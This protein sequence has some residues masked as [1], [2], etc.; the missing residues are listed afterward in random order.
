M[1]GGE[2]TYNY[3]T[4]QATGS[5][6]GFYDDVVY[7][8]MAK[9]TNRFFVTFE[10]GKYAIPNNQR[11]SIGTME[12]DHPHVT[13]NSGN[14]VT[15]I[16]MSFLNPNA[17]RTA[18]PYDLF[19]QDEEKQQITNGGGTISVG[20]IDHQNNGY[21]TITELKGDRSFRSTL[22]ASVFTTPTY[23]YETATVLD[24]GSVSSV[25]S[26]RLVSASYFYPFTQYQLA[27]LRDTPG[28]ILN[29]DKTSELPNGT[30]DDGYVL[31][32]ENTH[33]TVKDNLEYYLEKAGLIEKTTIT[34]APQKPERGGF[35]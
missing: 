18:A 28:I 31:V 27:V 20:G 21:I 11:E 16:T 14:L 6:A 12:I 24:D 32:P 7:W 19:L 3:Y 8:E 5:L 2:F 17:S 15:P 25:E 35:L 4:F 30:G 10:K 34:K 1:P 23:H 26:T 9:K 33:P 22:T 13:A 29:L